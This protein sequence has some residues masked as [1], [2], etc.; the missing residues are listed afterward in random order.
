MKS[1]FGGLQTFLKNHSQAFRIEKGM[2]RLRRWPEE[3]LDF[4]K[5]PGKFKR[6]YCWFFSQHPQGKLFID[7]F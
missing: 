6:S 1:Q 2:A 7:I 5:I 3:Y 4:C